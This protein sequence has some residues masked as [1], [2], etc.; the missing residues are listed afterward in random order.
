MRSNKTRQNRSIS[1]YF[2]RKFE[3]ERDSSW[4]L[5]SSNNVYKENK[6]IIPDL[7]KQKDELNTV[8]AQL[9]DFDLEE[10]SNHTKSRDP[11][12]SIIN[13]IKYTYKAELVTQAWC[14]F[15]ECVSEFPVISTKVIDQRML[16]SVHLCE[17][18]G[19]FICALNHFLQTQITK[20]E[21][22]WIGSTLNPYYEGNSEMIP[23]DR[24]IRHTSKNWYFGLDL[25]GDITKFYNSEALVDLVKAKMKVQLVTADGSIN[26]M[27]NPGDQ[28]RLVE[29]LHYCEAMTALQILETGG[30][31]VIKIFTIFE[32]STIC[33]MYLLN[34]C[35]EKVYVFKPCT[36]KSGNSELY[37]ICLNYM[38]ISDSLMSALLTPYIE[39]K[40]EKS[41][42]SLNHI[43][44]SFLDQIHKCARFFMDKQIQVINENIKYFRNMDYEQ[45]KLIA[46]LTNNVVNCFFK[47]YKILTLSNEFKIVTDNKV[48]ILYHIAE[49]F[50]TKENDYVPCNKINIEDVD[51][52][53]I[54]DI[55]IGKYIVNLYHSKYHT[56]TNFSYN[57]NKKSGALYNLSESLL[58]NTNNIIS[59]TNFDQF[60]GVSKFH[61]KFFLEILCNFTHEKNLIIVGVPLLTNFLVGLVFLI[62]LAFK[63]MWF[64]NNAVILEKPQH[65]KVEDVRKHLEVINKIYHDI[66]NTN[67]VFT[68]DILHV[69]PFDCVYNKRII[70]LVSNYNDCVLK[71]KCVC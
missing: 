28:E 49:Y 68:K 55:Q 45:K 53:S 29:Y 9:N 38:P 11:S 56:V 5:P 48:H 70:R 47:K 20:I 3:F 30:S 24:F 7:Q 51:I 19:A 65:S 44:Y 50:L 39:G 8:K 15:Y 1:K 27:E 26:C 25:T 42:F 4:N 37:V 52:P 63:R 16:N 71:Y 41:M 60:Y 32:E 34:C 36:S 13:N 69:V 31:L 33:L 23:D 67:D 17:A 2:N 61:R 22:N 35:F 62:S 46:D 12:R 59:F 58:C 57:Q 40:L 64:W 21:W 14:K 66:D 54:L 43:S 18:P 6:F 10:W